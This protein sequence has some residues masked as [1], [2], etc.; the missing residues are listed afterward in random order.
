MQRFHSFELIQSSIRKQDWATKWN[1]SI[2]QATIQQNA[3][4]LSMNLWVNTYTLKPVHRSTSTRHK[5]IQNISKHIM[6]TYSQCN[7]GNRTPGTTRNVGTKAPPEYLGNTFKHRMIRV[8]L[9]NVV[10]F[11]LSPPP[12]SQLYV[13]FLLFH[14]AFVLTPLVS[15]CF[16]LLLI[17]PILRP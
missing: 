2:W 7:W 16:Q 9:I 8:F 3:Y 6:I 10:V 4:K 5:T 14:R 11:I 12:F 13:W 15:L 1:Y 17:F